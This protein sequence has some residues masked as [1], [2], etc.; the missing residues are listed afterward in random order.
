MIYA[1]NP[2]FVLSP[3]LLAVAVPCHL[4]LEHIPEAREHML[5]ISTALHHSYLQIKILLVL[6]GCH[7]RGPLSHCRTMKTLNST[8]AWGCIGE[9]QQFRAFHL[10][11]RELLQGLH[12]SRCPRCWKKSL[13]ADFNENLH[14]APDLWSFIL[15]REWYKILLSNAYDQKR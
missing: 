2:G 3:T 4:C 9:T 13:H 15:F 10:L 8:I 11:F 7:H 1:P 6:R 5:C 12:L 14:I